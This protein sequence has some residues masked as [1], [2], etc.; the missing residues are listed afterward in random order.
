MPLSASAPSTIYWFTVPSGGNSINTG[1]TFT[2]PSLS[3]TTTYYVQTGISCPSSR[4]PVFAT[5]NP[6]PANPITNGNSRCGAG[7]LILTATSSDPVTW[8][9]VATGGTSVGAGLSFTT[10]ALS[11]TTNYY[12]QASNGNCPSSRVLT[13]ATIITPAADPVVTPVQRCGP[14]TLTLTANSPNPVK[15]YDSASGGNQVGAGISF[16]TPVLFST[17]T[18]YAQADNGCLSNR[19]AGVA[20]VNAQPQDPATTSD[21]RC[22]PGTLTLGASSVD[23]VTWYDANTGGNI[24]GTGSAFVTPS[25]SSTTIFYAGANKG[26]C[27]SNRIVTV[28]KVLPLPL[29]N[30]GADTI[31]IG[32]FFLIDAGS[33]FKSYLWSS[34]ET[35]QTITI[36]TPGTYCVTVS[37]SNNCNNSDCKLV[38]L[39]D[40][41]SG[42]SMNKLFTV[43]PNPANGIISI[44]FPSSVK[45]MNIEIINITGS[46]LWRNDVVNTSPISINLYGFSGGIYFLKINTDKYSEIQKLIIQ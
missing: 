33:G 13:V 25:I 6:V 35:T 19:V 26:T 34:G 8:Y 5:V 27:L 45:N 29:I 7:T 2:T 46:V 21:Q 22:G 38:D 30:L 18:Y 31:V 9:D 20:S 24:V 14:G 42:L 41:I 1:Q 11:S 16:T 15:W 4:I 10:P 37:D 36:S 12:A 43:Y 23:S 3:T 39:S 44:S 32:T 40:G 28:A 17:T